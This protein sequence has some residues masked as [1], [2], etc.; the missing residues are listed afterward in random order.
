[1]KKIIVIKD[2]LIKLVVSFIILI[3]LILNCTILKRY[4]F[5][6]FVITMILLII[7]LV[8]SSLKILII[9]GK[10]IIVNGD[11]V[12]L[13]FK[14]QYGEKIN[15]SLVEEIRLKSTNS[16]YSS[17]GIEKYGR[18]FDSFRIDH[19]FLEFIYFDKTIKRICVNNFT[20]KEIDKIC[21]YSKEINN[22]I[23]I[24]QQ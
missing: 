22:T 16:F 10:F 23:N 8:L 12:P 19:K 5:L 1:M 17:R 18:G 11:F 21:K 20:K 4:F 13:T 6:P 15:L 24:K 14:I 3:L 2:S 9:N 7:F